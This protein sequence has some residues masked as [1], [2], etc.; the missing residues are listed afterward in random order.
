MFVIKT[1]TASFN[2]VAPDMKLE[3]TIQSSNKGSGGI[4]RQTRQKAFVSKRELVYH[5]INNSFSEITKLGKLNNS[6]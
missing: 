1:N 5:A 6:D 4:V 3:Q 2:A